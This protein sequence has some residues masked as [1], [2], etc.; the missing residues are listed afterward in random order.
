MKIQQ[1]AQEMH[2]KEMKQCTFK[3]STNV[4]DPSKRSVNAFFTD[5]LEYCKKKNDKIEE[6]R[7]I[8]QANK[9][10]QNIFRPNAL[11]HPNHKPEDVQKV[12]ERLYGESKNKDGSTLRKDSCEQ[13]NTSM[14]KSN[15]FKGLSRGNSS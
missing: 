1:I 14:T 7:A 10:K 11:L 8:I 9:A 12:H 3:P 4:L 15:R 5:Q 6:M 2:Q 13:K